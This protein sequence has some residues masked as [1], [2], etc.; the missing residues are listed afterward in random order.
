VVVSGHV[1]E[2]RRTYAVCLTCGQVSSCRSAIE[3]VIETFLH[4][5]H[6]SERTT[7]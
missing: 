7:S 1:V 5:H 4:M 2:V 6:T 3:H